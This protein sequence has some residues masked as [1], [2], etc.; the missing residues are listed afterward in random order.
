MAK[1]LK[2]EGYQERMSSDEAAARV[3]LKKS[4]RRKKVVFNKR[5]VTSSLAR[6]MIDKDQNFQ[7]VIMWYFVACA[8]NARELDRKAL[9]EVGLEISSISSIIPL[10]RGTSEFPAGEIKKAVDS[11][12]LQ[13]I[14]VDEKGLFVIRGCYGTYTNRKLLAMLFYVVDE[15]S[16]RQ[17]S[18]NKNDFPYLVNAR[19][20]LASKKY[21]AET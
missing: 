21:G 1:L 6:K 19:Q 5:E 15:L 2:E 16:G 10:Q 17:L 20:L 12:N 7:M 13:H 3:I 4:L 14:S 9:K 18:S 11:L 8:N